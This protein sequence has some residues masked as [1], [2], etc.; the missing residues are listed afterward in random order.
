MSITDPMTSP[1]RARRAA[2]VS[3]TTPRC[4][5]FTQS[6]LNPNR[7]FEAAIAASLAVSERSTEMKRKRLVVTAV[8]LALPA[9]AVM[10]LATTARSAPAAGNKKVALLLPESKTTRYEAHDHPEFASSLKKFCPDCTLLYSNANQDAARQQQQA[11]AAISQGAKVLVLDPV[12]FKS[13]VSIVEYANAR[14]VPVVDWERLISNAKI[15]YYVSYD[16]DKVGLLQ[17]EALTAKLASLGKAKGPI[18]KI[19]GSPTDSNAL[20]FKKASSSV[21]MAKGVAV[22][23]EYDTPD[24][25]PDQAQNE[26]QQAITALGKDGFVGVYAAND[27]T[28]GGAI[29]AMRAAGIDPKTVPVTGQDAET[30]ALQRVLVGEQFMTIYKAIFPEAVLAAKVAAALANGKP[31]PKSTVNRLVNNGLVRVPSMVLKPT[32]VTKSN[33]KSTVVRDKFV[34]VKDLCRGSYASACAAAG[35]H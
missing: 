4:R 21:F 29:A 24:W 2:I 17:A 26:M 22:A 15:A 11:E 12:D 16:N 30:A 13:A 33:I 28:A 18:V 9:G 3:S 32:V 35:I 19:N 23:K 34:S 31:I 1:D 27:G 6:A 20:Q 10:G 14:H 5:S 7:G 8:A 25:S